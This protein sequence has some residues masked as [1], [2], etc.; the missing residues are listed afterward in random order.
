MRTYYKMSINK[1]LDLNIWLQ[2]AF[3]ARIFIMLT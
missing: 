2:L 3:S 1:A